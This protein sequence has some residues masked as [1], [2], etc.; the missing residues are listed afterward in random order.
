MLIEHI[1]QFNIWLRAYNICLLSPKRSIS[2]IIV[3]FATLQYAVGHICG[4]LHVTS[5][6]CKNSYD[7]TELEC[8]VYLY[9]LPC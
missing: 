7:V 5:Y 2:A 9:C 8:T 1:F 3:V 6:D 4:V